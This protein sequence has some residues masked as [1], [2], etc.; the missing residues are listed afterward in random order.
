MAKKK[1]RSANVAR[2]REKRKRDRK[3]R[4][5]QLAIEKQRRLPY[6]R[7][8][9]ERLYTCLVKTPDLIEEPEL[10]SLHFDLDLMYIEMGKFLIDIKPELESAFPEYAASDTLDVKSDISFFNNDMEGNPQDRHEIFERFQTEV[11]GRLITPKFMRTLLSALSA[12]E[13]RL[14][15][16]GERD[17]AEVAFFAQF[18]FSEVPPD[19]FVE[20]PLIQAIGM[21]TLRLLVENPPPLHE[22]HP[23][24]KTIVS[25]VLAN[26]DEDS[27]SQHEETLSNMFSDAIGREHSAANV[28]SQQV[29]PLDTL[30]IETEDDPLVS[31]SIPSPDSLPAKAL[32]KNFEGLAIKEVLKKWQGPSLAKETATQL[33]YFDE[34]QELYITVTESRVQL[35]AYSEAELDMA[36]DEFEDHCQSTVMYLAKTYEEGGNTDGTE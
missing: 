11:I 15:R 20:H 14:R 27:E 2:K 4:H 5:K 31:E 24:V 28:E 6:G 16:T 23:I 36:M 7:M 12:C 35:H 26:K 10:E 33:D 13:N 25:E 29:D 19:V 3:T 21:Q 34:K 18:L 8:D 17:L 22:E 32:Y 9:E 1:S 30:I